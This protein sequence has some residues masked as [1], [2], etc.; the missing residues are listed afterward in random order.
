MY[1]EAKSSVRAL[2]FKVQKDEE[3]PQRFIL[4]TVSNLEIQGQSRLRGKI[5]IEYL[6][7]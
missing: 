4:P 5:L 2:V 1:T 3:P 7:C 6:H